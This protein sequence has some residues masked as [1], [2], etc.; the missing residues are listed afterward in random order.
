VEEWRVSRERCEMEREFGASYIG[1]REE[2]RG[3]VEAVDSGHADG[4]H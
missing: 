2:W 4:R 3:A 1:P